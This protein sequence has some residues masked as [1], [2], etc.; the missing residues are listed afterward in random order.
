MTKM[1]SLILYILERA[2]PRDLTWLS[3]VIYLSDLESYHRSGK[4]ITGGKWFKQ[5]WG[6][7]VEG[8]SAAVDALIERGDIVRS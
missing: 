2:G 8:F 5:P 1:E 6:I 3:L 7:E 4:T